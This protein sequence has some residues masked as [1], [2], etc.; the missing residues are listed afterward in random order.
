MVKKMSIRAVLCLGL[1]A[2][3]QQAIADVADTL[4]VQVDTTAWQGGVDMR[5]PVGPSTAVKT[6]KSGR[7]AQADR[8]RTYDLGGR[9]VARP[10]GRG[11][12]IRNGRKYVAR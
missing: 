7:T 2:G 5:I 1:L 11:L 6:V 8:Q 3:A 12:Y 9:P 10:A 4:T